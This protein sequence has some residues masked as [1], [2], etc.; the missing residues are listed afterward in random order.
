MR[1][2]R[3]LFGIS[4]ILV[5]ASGCGGSNPTGGVV[6][7]VVQDRTILSK[8][9][10]QRTDVLYAGCYACGSP[11]ADPGGCLLLPEYERLA[12]L[13]N[14]GTYEQND[15]ISITQDCVQNADVWVQ[16]VGRV[17]YG[18]SFH[19]QLFVESTSEL[20]GHATC[21]THSTTNL[22]CDLIMNAVVP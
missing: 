22:E 12:P 7:P 19:L 3:S 18:C 8:V 9:W 17:P 10:A 5:I 6:E 16:N 15:V 21:S 2:R 13:N 20:I 1:K 11:I 4:L 14:F